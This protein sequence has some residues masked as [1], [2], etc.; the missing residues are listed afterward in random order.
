MSSIGKSVLPLCL[1]C[2]LLQWA[3]SGCYRRV[4]CYLYCT[5]TAV[6]LLSLCTPL[7]REE[8]RREEISKATKKFLFCSDVQCWPWLCVTS[9]SIF[10]LSHHSFGFLYVKDPTGTAFR[11]CKDEMCPLKAIIII[12]QIITVIAITII[13]P[14]KC[15]FNVLVNL[16]KSKTFDVF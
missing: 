9:Q 7:F 13:I 14:V 4:D 2:V 10:Y 1:L 11:L 12:I 5:S 8:R 16:I 3:C 15:Q 6:A